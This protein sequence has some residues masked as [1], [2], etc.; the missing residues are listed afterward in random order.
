[1]LYT[2]FLSPL[3]AGAKPILADKPPIRD[4]TSEFCAVLDQVNE[5]GADVR[6]LKVTHL[7][8]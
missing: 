5:D 3:E 4:E 8:L 7:L 1:M 6:L 2:A